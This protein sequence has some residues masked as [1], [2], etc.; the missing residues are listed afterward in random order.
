MG[1]IIRDHEENFFQWYL[2]NWQSYCD[3]CWREK[4]FEHFECIYFLPSNDCSLVISGFCINNEGNWESC[5]AKFLG[6]PQFKGPKRRVPSNTQHPKKSFVNIGKN[7]WGSRKHQLK[8]YENFKK[9]WVLRTPPPC[10]IGLIKKFSTFPIWKKSI[11][12]NI[13]R[14]LFFSVLFSYAIRT[15]E[16]WQP[17]CQKYNTS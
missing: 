5:K 2:E 9:Q 13:A 14:L 3:F 17:D 15:Q 16:S 10:Q 8:S 11:T 6:G 7:I 1:V 12:F 4:Y